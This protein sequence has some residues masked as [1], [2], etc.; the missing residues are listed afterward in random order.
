MLYA[1]DSVIIAESLKELGT[2]YATWKLCMEG[3]ELKV[4]LAKNN[5]MISEVN[6]GLTFTS[7]KHPCGAYC[8][9][10][11]SNFIYC[12]HCTHWVHKGC[13]GLYGRLDSV[14][15]FKCRICLKLA[16]ANV[17]DKKVQLGNVQYEVVDQFY[18]LG[19]MLSARGGTQ[20][21][22]YLVIGQI[23][24][25]LDSFSLTSRVFSL[26]MKW[27]FYSACIRSV[28]LYG[29]KTWPLKESDISRIA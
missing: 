25:N 6:R 13:C 1:V 12:N 3:K 28:M 5:V 16:V 26:K 10:I 2:W 17:D 15:D 8:K 18:Q 24:K 29:S 14:V 11:G 20:Q 7:R 21:V 27:K 22:E 9:S 19:D 23:G 4:N